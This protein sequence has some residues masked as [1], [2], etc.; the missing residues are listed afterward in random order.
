MTEI[1]EKQLE[2]IHP[3]YA[4]F[5]HKVISRG[6]FSF[7]I[8][9]DPSLSPDK[10]G[11]KLHGVS[12]SCIDATYYVQD[13][14]TATLLLSILF[15]LKNVYAI[16]HN[17][18]YDCKCL[19]AAK[20][21]EGYPVKLCDTMIAANLV[22]DNLQPRELGLKP[23]V[24]EIFNHNM[25][26]FEAAYQSGGLD[27]PTFIQYAKDDAYWEAR[28]WVHL[29]QRMQQLGVFEYF[30]S[31]PTN[32]IFCDMEEWGFPVDVNKLWS[33]TLSMAKIRDSAESKVFE[34][35]GY[36][37]LNSPAQLSKRLFEDLGYSTVG[38]SK[39]PS[40]KSWATDEAAIEVLAEKYPAC[41]LIRD[42]RTADKL[43]ST[44]ITPMAQ[45][46]LKDPHSVVRGHYWLFSK[47]GRTRCSDF[48]LQN[49]PVRL[50]DAFKGLNIKEAFVPF[51]DHDLIVADL[52]NLE[53]RMVAHI[54]GDREMTSA[55]L[56]WKCNE[57]GDSGQSQSIL[58]NCPTCGAE[59][60]EAVG[61]EIAGAPGFYHGIDLHTRTSRIPAVGG[62]RDKAKAANFALVYM[63]TAY[64][65]AAEF[66]GTTVAEWEAISE[67]YFQMYSGVAKWHDTIWNNIN[68]GKTFVVIEPFGRRRTIT[69]Q[70]IQHSKKH[71][72]NL[73]ANFGPQSGGCGLAQRGLKKFRDSEIAFGRYGTLVRPVNFIHDEIVVS[74]HKSVSHK[75]A[76]NLQHC[77]ET[78]VRLR[79]PMR[80]SCNICA[81]WYEGK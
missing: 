66:P 23:L 76:A 61:K 2:A 29:A 35:I 72:A 5:I 68:V 27:S 20:W 37:N 60:N 41:A 51:P 52:S 42:F 70:M 78:A 44:F 54:T 36:L 57:C 34:S 28:L 26:E 64:R 38:I 10:V 18:K 4:E 21:V 62:N 45:Y 67:Q 33:L 12:L 7:D 43:L 17:C 25:M 73:A 58:H 46:A 75:V 14:P 9:H 32:E 24:R 55:F 47:T 15:K 30:L 65:M 49:I 79:V 13:Q 77:L 16:A 59:E 11:F 81:N 40:G 6:F 48:N 74:A 71:C 1:E 50:P 39:T 53:L 56:T 19:H 63:A 80:S 69:S 3:E 8:E 31:V 22:D